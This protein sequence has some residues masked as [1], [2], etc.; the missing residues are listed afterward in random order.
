MKNIA[1]YHKDLWTF[2]DLSKQF[3]KISTSWHSVNSDLTTGHCFMNSMVADR[4][5]I[6]LESRFRH[7]DNLY[8]LLIV[9]IH[10]IRSFNLHAKHLKLVVQGFELFTCNAT[11]DNFRAK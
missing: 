1:D 7:G 6:L 9:Y 11:T 5:M 8:H 4:Q 10:V 3:G 2:Q